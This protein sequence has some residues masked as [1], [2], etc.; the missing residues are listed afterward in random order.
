MSLGLP[1]DNCPLPSPSHPEMVPAA[2]FPVVVEPSLF[3][4]ESQHPGWLNLLF[5]RWGRHI[6]NPYW[7]ASEGQ[8]RDKS[9][10]LECGM[11]GGSPGTNR[12]F[13]PMGSAL[14]THG[15]IIVVAII[16]NQALLLLHVEAD[17]VME[18]S[19]LAFFDFTC[20]KESK[21][22]DLFPFSYATAVPLSRVSDS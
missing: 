9:D 17:P 15:S 13:Q 20:N 2:S 5:S 11:R 3:E 12:L 10:S 7:A 22:D 14:S 6:H 8:M 16:V 18:A 19:D 4:R 21:V 1:S